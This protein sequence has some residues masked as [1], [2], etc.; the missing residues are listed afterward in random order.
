[1]VAEYYELLANVSAYSGAGYGVAVNYFKKHIG[2]VEHILNEIE[3][4]H[5]KTY[6]R[7]GK[8]NSKAF[9]GHRKLMFQ[10]LDNVLKSMVGR[11]RMGLTL[12]RRNIK[13]SLGLNTK[14]LVHQLK[15]HPV[16]ISN[17]PDF[18][19]NHN[20]VIGYGKI[21]KKAGYVGLA[22]DGVHSAT[23]VHALRVFIVKAADLVVVSLV[24]PVV[25]L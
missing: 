10:Q 14:S 16:P 12:D 5:V 18:E 7:T 9:F 20:K 15:N 24:V 23:K 11:S 17:I 13:Q 1:V 6:N 22:L 21:L 2:Q 25:E 4:L 19:K 3:K 8:F